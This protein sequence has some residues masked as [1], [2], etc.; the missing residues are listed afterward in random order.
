MNYSDSR[1]LNNLA[2]REAAAIVW[3]LLCGM[4]KAK[5]Y[6]LTAEFI[7]G[8]EA[9]RIGLVSL[10][11]PQD[12]LMPRA[13]EIAAKL[14]NGG[15]QAVRFAKKSLNNWMLVTGPIFDNSPAWQCSALRQLAEC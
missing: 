15:R 11:V 6:L 2:M 7:D 9:G 4:A 1:H 10:C 13:M 3:P 12:K 5:Y 14:A 8:K